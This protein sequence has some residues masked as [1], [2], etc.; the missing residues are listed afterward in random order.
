MIITIFH[1]YLKLWWQFLWQHSLCSNLGGIDPE[2]KYQAT[3]N[4]SFRQYP[5]D[6]LTQNY[7][8]CLG[9]RG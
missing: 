9:R 4:H 8:P 2:K 5:I 7:I 3:L 6:R 1:L